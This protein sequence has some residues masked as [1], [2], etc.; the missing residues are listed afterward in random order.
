MPPDPSS[1]FAKTRMVPVVTIARVADAVPLARALV[2]G[3]LPVIE[4]TR[5]TESALAAVRVIAE[6]VANAVVGLGTVTQEADIE[7]AIQAWAKFL[8]SPGTPAA[9]AA[10]LAQAP[11]P[12][13]PGC[14]T[15]SEAMMLA[16]R[17]FKVLKFFPAEA[18]GGIA[19]L[20]AVAE[21]LPTIRFCPTGGINRNNAAAYLALPNVAA[22]GGS[23]ITPQD[24]V[25]AG[26][27]AR[28]TALAREAAQLRA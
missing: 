17:G 20:K 26:D 15:V 18:S 2:A 7:L 14:A 8:V 11:L 5:R 4:V 22:V 23:W 28:V 12:C 9:L 27:F 1:L 10:A 24:A 6:E 19:W 16:D 25:A 13:L 3:G 21:P